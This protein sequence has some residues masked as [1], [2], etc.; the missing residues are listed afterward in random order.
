M[1]MDAV[2]ICLRT[3]EFFAITLTDDEASAVR[4]VGDFYRLI[5]SKLSLDP[6]PSPVTSAKLPTITHKEKSFLFLSTRTPLPAPPEV[7]PWSP[8]SVWDTLF[9][10]LVDQLSL[11][12]T[13]ILYTATF[14][15]DLGIC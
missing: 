13:E 10:I 6:L 4:T 12:P 7:L 2:E 8:Q 1:G 9:A 3:E 15:E 5:C 11:K 14:T